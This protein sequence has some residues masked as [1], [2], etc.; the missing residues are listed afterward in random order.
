MSSSI[1]DKKSDV[2]PDDIFSYNLDKFYD[3]VE[4]WYGNDLA[5]LLSF[6][7]I[8]N[9]SHLLN[10]TVDD[11]LSVLQYESE[12]VI[13]LRNLCCFQLADNRFQIRLG[14]KLAI[15]NLI[16]CLTRKYEQ[17]R[18][19]KRSYGQRS[20]S[21]NSVSVSSNETQ[22]RTGAVV[23][24]SE[25]HLPPTQNKMTEN[26][27]V[28]DIKQRVSKWWSGINDDNVSFEEGTQY[29]LEINRSINNSYACVLSCRCGIRFKLHFT[30]AG[31]FK[32]SSFFRHIKEQ[33]CAQRFSNVSIA[34]C[35]SS[36][37]DCLSHL[38]KCDS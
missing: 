15:S 17:Q 3:F 2:L 9:G 34:Y 18:K 1:P 13:K 37:Y 31:I 4:Q 25:Q 35:E 7:A 30:E 14:V 20:S 23:Q 22:L 11:I 21:D 6:Q 28:R 36:L 27:H 5:Q 29:I 26:D 16:E 33:N 38:E 24:P 8:R 12:D 19:L 10:T 32:L